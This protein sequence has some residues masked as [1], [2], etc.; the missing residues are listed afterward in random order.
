[1]PRHFYTYLKQIVTE[2]VWRE[3]LVHKRV[4]RWDALAVSARE[5]N[6]DSQSEDRTTLTTQHHH[7][8]I[9]RLDTMSA[10]RSHTLWTLKYH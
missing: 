2:G 10:E 4:T 5:D 6:Y 3:L 7:S 9:I 8:L 1:M